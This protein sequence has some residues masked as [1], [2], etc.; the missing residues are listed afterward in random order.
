MSDL[1]IL[2]TDQ[3]L[4]E[5]LAVSLI[6]RHLGQH[7]ISWSQTDGYI[8]S[9]ADKKTKSGYN[10]FDF[11]M[12]HSCIDQDLGA[13][14]KNIKKYHKKHFRRLVNYLIPHLQNLGNDQYLLDLALGSSRT[15]IIQTLAQQLSDHCKYITQRQYH[16]SNS[17]LL[18]RNIIHNESILKDLLADKSSFWFLDTGY[19]NHL[20]DKKVW[21]RVVANHIHA[22]PD[23]S[24]PWPADRLHQL[25]VLPEPWH[26]KGTRI[27]VVESSP[28]HYQI[29]DDD[30]ERWRQRI[31]DQV[32][33]YRPGTS[34]E[35]YCKQDRKVRTSVWEY[36]RQDPKSWYCVINDSSA[37]A[38]E[39]V[40]LGI[41]VITLR[42]HVTTPIACTDISQIN[43]LYRGPIGNWLCAL[44]YSQFTL[45]EI[46]N[47]IARKIIRKFHNV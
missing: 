2:L 28:S 27:L 20:T 19:T 3:E 5:S 35:F 13:W 31:N 16:Q 33:Q 9:C 10:E 45:H 47:G 39:A 6:S 14:Q 38:I 29:Y 44:T 36:L 8:Q 42:P 17:T 26:H 7:S 18:L 34:V 41:P 12:F 21:H 37:A 30:L 25:S 4:A 46:Q 24:R 40:W 1:K 11:V 22:I 15:G 43:N 23:I 32:Q